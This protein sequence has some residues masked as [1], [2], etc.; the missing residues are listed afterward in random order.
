MALSLA[1]AVLSEQRGA[2]R[3]HCRRPHRV[4]DA[5]DAASVPGLKGAALV[6]TVYTEPTRREML[7]ILDYK[8]SACHES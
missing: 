8:G 3:L 7:D 2:P 5:L 1:D 4:P 6:E